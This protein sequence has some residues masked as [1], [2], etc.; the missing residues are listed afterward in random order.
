LEVTHFDFFNVLKN[1]PTL[2]KCI[3]DKH[4]LVS[5]ISGR[6]L[7]GISTLSDYTHIL[8]T[9]SCS[10]RPVVYFRELLFKFN[11]KKLS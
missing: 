4:G 8:L 6:P 7:S 9:L 11:K 2:A 1:E 5:L 10:E 3:F